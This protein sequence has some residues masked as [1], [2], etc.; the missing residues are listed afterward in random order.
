MNANGRICRLHAVID[1][2]KYEPGPIKASEAEKILGWTGFEALRQWEGEVANGDPL[3]ARA[4][5]ALMKFR[6][7][8]HVRFGDID[9]EDVDSIEADLRDE[10]GR[11]LSTKMDEQGR[12]VVR[13]GKQVFLFDGEED[14]DPQMAASQPV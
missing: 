10:D 9:I 13:A 5:I 4:L 8:E 11:V 1:G 3:A 14:T 6:Q 2:T 12:P 7:G